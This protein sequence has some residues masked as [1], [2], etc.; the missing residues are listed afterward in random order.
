LGAPPVG[1]LAWDQRSNHPEH[2]NRVDCGG[3][4]ALR[5]MIIAGD[6]HRTQLQPGRLS[7]A[8]EGN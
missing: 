7:G 4:F 2:N 8:A 1:C 3:D 5:A 6:T